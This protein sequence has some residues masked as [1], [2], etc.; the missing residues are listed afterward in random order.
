MNYEEL[1]NAQDGTPTQREQLPVGFYYKKLID[2]RYRHVVQLKPSLIESI[3]F[4]E[5]LKNDQATTMNIHSKEQ[6]HYVL[7]EDSGG[8]YEME[9]EHGNYQPLTQ[10]LKVNPAVVASKGFVD[11]M[12][13]RLMTFTEEL[14]REGIYHLCY[15]PQSVFVGKGDNNPMLLCHGSSFMG[16]NDLGSLYEGLE[17][18]VAPEVLAHGHIDA[19]SDVYSLGKL[20]EYIFE[21]SEMPYEIK[22]MVKKATAADPAQR[23]K[24]ID[25]MRSAYKNRRSMR[26][27]LI[28]LAVALVVVL[29]AVWA[30]FELV[31]EPVVVEYE[32]HPK[33]DV[34]EV[35]S[36]DPYTS[37][38]LYDPDMLELLGINHDSIDL[39]ILSDEELRQIT[40]SASQMMRAEAIF[41]KNFQR[42]AERRLSKIYDN[43]YMGA[44]E[45][46]VMANSQS[47]MDDLMQIKEE[48]ARSAGLSDDR[49]GRIYTEI[50]T[51]ITTERQKKAEAEA[52]A[53]AA[54]AAGQ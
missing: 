24:S 31:P 19:S 25:N 10:L 37:E 40:D 35:V 4:R 53:E 9:L 1:L 6:L 38:E 47:T 15:A 13:D 27:S 21:S 16:M 14:H 34:G 20:I 7:H 22:H 54:A 45:Q 49:A 39:S 26:L 50:I 12:I 3:V 48:L 8:L 52:E 18:F 36:D 28:S 51:Q 42:E 46:K 33:G 30:Y 32:N 44:N 11:N 2:Q 5:A 23:F 41:R 17:D 43:N 29:L